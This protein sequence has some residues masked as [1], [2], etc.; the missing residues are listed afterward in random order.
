MPY[1]VDAPVD[2]WPP[3]APLPTLATIYTSRVDDPIH[4]SYIRQREN[5]ASKKPGWWGTWATAS[6]LS[7]CM[8]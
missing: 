4:T 6:S 5:A 2:A 8:P 7:S 1:T 3:A